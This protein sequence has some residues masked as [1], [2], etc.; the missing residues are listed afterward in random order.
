MAITNTS[1]TVREDIATGLEKDK[2]Y[3][4]NVTVITDY[5]NATST[6]SFSERNLLMYILV[7]VEIYSFTN[8]VFI[9]NV[10]L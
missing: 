3:T 7:I 1:Q 2:N 6:T 5:G 4:L 9:N 10:F 8:I